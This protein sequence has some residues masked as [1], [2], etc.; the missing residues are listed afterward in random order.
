MIKES[1]FR[2]R[3]EEGLRK[4]FID[5]C[6]KKDQTASQEIRK[7]M[8]NYVEERDNYLQTGLQTSGSVVIQQS[9]RKIRK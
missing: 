3:V 8:R 9:D 1:G 2:V 5:A 6:R 4:A 7:F